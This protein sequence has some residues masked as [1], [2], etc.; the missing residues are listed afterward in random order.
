MPAT[1][2]QKAP[3]PQSEEP[4]LKVVILLYRQGKDI[5]AVIPLTF[6]IVN[7]VEDP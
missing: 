2:L 1:P 6:H 4:L 5:F 3:F 7:G